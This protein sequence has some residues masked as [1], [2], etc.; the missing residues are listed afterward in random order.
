MGSEALIYRAISAAMAAV[1]KVGKDRR[2]PDKMGGYAFRGVEAVVNAVHPVFVEQCVFVTSEKL[3][4]IRQERK[5]GSGGI[6]FWKQVSYRWTFWAVDGSSVSTEADGEAQDSGDKTSAKAYSVSYREAV[7]K[8]LS[9]PT[10]T[11][12]TE[13]EVHEPITETQRPQQR[14]R[15]MTPLEKLDH[16]LVHSK[17]NVDKLNEISVRWEQFLS[18][19]DGAELSAEDKEKAKAMIGA[20]LN[21]G[22]TTDGK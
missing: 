14:A 21:G 18:T 19:A 16:N 2:A 6:M 4:E 7:C 22:E 20:A 17:G 9:I 12:D 15:Q 13:S 5:T 8:I 10:D 3:G 11:P 1:G